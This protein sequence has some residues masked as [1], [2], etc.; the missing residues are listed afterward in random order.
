MYHTCSDYVHWTTL[1]IVGNFREF[2]PITLFATILSKNASYLLQYSALWYVTLAISAGTSCEDD[3]F[4]LWAP[5]TRFRRVFTSVYIQ[6]KRN[7]VLTPGSAEIRCCSHSRCRWYP[8]KQYQFIASPHTRARAYVRVTRSLSSSL[9]SFRASQNFFSDP[10]IIPKRSLYCEK[11][12]ARTFSRNNCEKKNQNEDRMCHTR[13][14][15]FFLCRLHRSLP[16]PA[17][18]CLCHVLQDL[19]RAHSSSAFFLPLGL[20]RDTRICKCHFLAVFL[21]LSSLSFCKS[22]KCQFTLLVRYYLVFSNNLPCDSTSCVYFYFYFL[23]CLLKYFVKYILQVLPF[24]WSLH[25]TSTAFWLKIFLGTKKNRQLIHSEC[26]LFFLPIVFTSCLNTLAPVPRTD[27]RHRRALSRVALLSVACANRTSETVWTPTAWRMIKRRVSSISFLRTRSGAIA[28][29]KFAPAGRD[30]S[31][32]LVRAIDRSSDRYSLGW[33][34][35]GLH[36]IQKP[37]IL[38]CSL[39]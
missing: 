22:A 17:N 5:T 10:E 18:F 38:H 23:Q 9:S 26:P 4:L 6:S 7:K 11:R 31:V 12:Q 24:L 27:R 39:K 14:R 8:I 1:N 19:F 30:A 15:D 28:P 3:W 37:V 13:V 33:T 16:Q 36:W 34:Q 20:S 29:P 35:D 21:Y 25:F 32:R 2:S